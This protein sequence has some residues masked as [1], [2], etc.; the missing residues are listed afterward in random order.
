MRVWHYRESLIKLLNLKY[1][2]FFPLYIRTMHY[3]TNGSFGAL[4]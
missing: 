3:G 4:W 1:L 2:S